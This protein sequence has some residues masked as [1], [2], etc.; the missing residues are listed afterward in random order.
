MRLEA[1]AVQHGSAAPL[2]GGWKLRAGGTLDLLPLLDWLADC[3]D[4]GKG[5]AV[6]HAPMPPATSS[7]PQSQRGYSVTPLA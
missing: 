3:V 5:A 7:T 1:L 6:F 4:P 2:E